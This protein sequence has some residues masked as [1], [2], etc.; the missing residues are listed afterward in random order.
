M[1]ESVQITAKG[2]EAVRL[3]DATG[4]RLHEVVQN[5]MRLPPQIVDSLTYRVLTGAMTREEYRAA[6]NE[7]RRRYGLA[8][9]PDR[10]PERMG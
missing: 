6:L 9:I 3:M 8:P 5:E 7:Q 2:I 4:M 10:D 1:N